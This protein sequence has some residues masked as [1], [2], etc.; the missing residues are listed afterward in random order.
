MSQ[1]QLEKKV[2]N[3]LR[4]SQALEEYLQHPLSSERLQAEMDRMA[5]HTKQPE[6]LREL[7]DALGNDPFVIA[8]CLARQT[9]AQRRVSKVDNQGRANVVRVAWLKQPLQPSVTRAK[10]KAPVRMAAFNASYTLPAISEGPGCIDDTWV[11]TS[12]TNAPSPRNSHTAVWTGSEMIVW[13]GFVPPFNYFNTGGKYNPATDSWTATSTANAPDARTGHTAVWTG[14]EMIVWGGAAGSPKSFTDSGGR[15]NPA[16]DSWIPTSITSAPSP[17]SSHTAVLTGTEMIVWGGFDL[18]GDVNSGGSY[19]PNTDSWTAIS[20]TNVPTARDTHTAVWTGSEMIIWGGEDNSGNLLD[21]GGRY[22]PSTNSWTA[23]ST[24]NAPIGRLFHTAIWGGNEMIVW[25]GSNGG[26]TYYNTGGRYNSGTDTWTAT[27]TTNATQRSFHTA[28][29]T[30]NE[31]IVWAG[32]TSPGSFTDTGERY[33]PGTDSWTPTSTT[34]APE[35]RSE[36]TAVWT[37]TEMIVWGGTSATDRLNT[38]GRYCAQAGPTPTPTPTGTP[39]STPHNFLWYNGDFNG[40]NGLANEENTSIGSGEFASVYDDFIVGDSGG[41]DVTAVF[42]DNLENT[43]VTGATWEIR[44]GIS[45]GNG[46]TLIASG[47][48]MTPVVTPTGR[49]GFGFTEYM[50]EV[51]GL[52]VHLPASANPYW[53]NVTVVGDLTGRSFNST[54]SGANC[55]GTPCGNNQNAFFNSNFFGANFTSTANEGQPSDFSMGVESFVC[56]GPS[57]TPTATPTATHTPTPTAT[58][59]ATSTA[60]HTPTAT[61]TAT[62]THTPSATPTATAT[63][64]ATPAARPSPTPRPR[65]TPAVRP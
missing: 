44:Q 38:G 19:D 26:F 22:N 32:G 63:A 51:I 47:M 54:T 36:H 58:A 65:P 25:G 31:M 59:T 46:G 60:T 7:F 49:S 35:G 28:V 6:V 15:Y 2:E 11:A 29:W 56:C 18:S 30:G 64:T 55:V 45:E 23:T 42:S 17:R 48:T 24:T 14:T 34:N 37:G 61:A 43:N 13:G 62:A 20:N 50:V 1:E 16:T 57:P 8:E 3:Y 41:W 4:T 9:L 40:L 5:Q 33:N 52:S 39:T 27:S 10:T 12:T 21:T 53:L